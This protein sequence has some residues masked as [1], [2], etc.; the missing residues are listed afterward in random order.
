MEGIIY[1]INC[2]N[3]DCYVGSTTEKLSRRES[4]HKSKMKSCPNRKLYKT[5]IERNIELKL[6][7]YKKVIYYSKKQLRFIEE[8]ARK[9]LKGNINQIK[10]FI[11]KEDFKQH[12]RLYMKEYRKRKKEKKDLENIS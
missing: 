6:I 9:E 10:C 8:Q 3:N 1:Y 11:S 4:K 5:L 7:Q 12:R 2:G